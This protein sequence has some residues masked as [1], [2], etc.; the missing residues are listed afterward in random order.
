MIEI[1]GTFNAIKLT[2]L[3]GLM[4]SNIS[5]SVASP[6]AEVGD[7]RPRINVEILKQYGIIE[8]PTNTWPISWKQI[9]SNLSR[10]S[11]MEFPVH[12]RSA[13]TRI[14][15]R[16]PAEFRFVYNSEAYFVYTLIHSL[17]DVDF[18]CTRTFYL[19]K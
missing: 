4:L 13:I 10:T 11:E 18:L 5:P 15:E 7:L 6:W 9:T 16:I 12:V 8:G 2:M 14:R 19:P 1:A 17:T 3:A